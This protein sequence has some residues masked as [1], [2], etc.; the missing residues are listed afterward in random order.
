M[1]LSVMGAGLAPRM[2]PGSG[3]LEQLTPGA[4]GGS[5]RAAAASA[6]GV[7]AGWVGTD[8]FG[9][10]HASTAAGFGGK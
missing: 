6:I 3:W 8:I 2:A 7:G 5:P 4:L 10:A 1:G 9:T